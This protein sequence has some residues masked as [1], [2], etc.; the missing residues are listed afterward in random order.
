MPNAAASNIINEEEEKVHKD[1][2]CSKSSKDFNQKTS[3][4]T[5]NELKKTTLKVGQ[6]V[7]E[8]I[9]SKLELLKEIYTTYSKYGDKL[10]Y[11]KMNYAG[12]H[13]FLKDN[14][15]LHTVK[16]ESSTTDHLSNRT[17]KSPKT[18]IT[19]SRTNNSSPKKLSNCSVI[20]GKMID[21]EAFC[22]FCSLTGIKNFDTSIKNKS[23]FDKNKGSSI[24][25]GESGKGTNNMEKGS[26]LMSSKDN[27]PMRMDFNL[28]LKS[29]E[30]VSTKL[31]PEKSLD[32]AMMIFLDNVIFLLKPNRI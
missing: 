21:S 25:F 29:L 1:L 11:N 20:K 2:I 32:E 22:I 27:V 9:E 23:H 24:S 16:R 4:T 10:N 13:N 8:I 17:V 7:I 5:E 3:R 14:D 6:D 19:S 30:V 28:F 26:S 12:F 18:A 31:H 15:L